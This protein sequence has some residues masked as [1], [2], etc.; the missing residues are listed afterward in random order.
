[1][2]SDF[3]ENIRERLELLKKVERDFEK[4]AAVQIPGRLRISR[5][6]NKTNYFHVMDFSDRQGKYIRKKEMKLASM[7]AQKTYENQM[8]V[9]L[10]N[11]INYLNDIVTAYPAKTFD[12]YL[13]SLPK[14]RQAL[15][16][17]VWLSDEEYTKQWLAQPYK[18]LGFSQHDTS[19]FITNAGIRVRSKSEVTIANELEKYGLPFLIELP[20]YLE[21]LGWINPDFAILIARLRKVIIWEH[22]GML[23]DRDYRENNF[24]KKNAA[25]IANGYFPGKNLIQTFESL[26]TPLSVAAVDRIIEELLI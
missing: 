15:I 9:L 8:L 16:T 25:Y 2:I 22:H 17:P 10:E 3:E 26:K 5:S 13:D 4:N 19:E 21:G 23:D 20:L 7:L 18:R 14:A 6:G 1:M 11:E 12:T 24:L